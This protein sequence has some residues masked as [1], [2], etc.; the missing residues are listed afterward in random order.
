MN[1]EKLIR[2]ANQTADFFR[3]YP[4]EQAVSG[5]HDHLVAFWTLRMRDAILAYADQGGGGLDP[6][7]AKALRMF[8]RGE[9]PIE[10]Q[11]AGPQK[12][13]PLGSDSG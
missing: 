7:V 3:S 4:E 10:K 5:I 13:D 8:R 1:P 6:L 9:S 12:A 2:T 11:V